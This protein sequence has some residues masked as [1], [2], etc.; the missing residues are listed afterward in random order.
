MSQEEMLVIDLVVFISDSLL[1]QSLVVL[2]GEAT[3]T[4]VR[5]PVGALRGRIYTFV[6]VRAGLGVHSSSYGVTPFDLCMSVAV[7]MVI[8]QRQR[9]RTMC[10][11]EL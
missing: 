6:P 4:L 3:R 5:K 9:S 7:S 11:K 1:Q 10:R 2:S 8:K